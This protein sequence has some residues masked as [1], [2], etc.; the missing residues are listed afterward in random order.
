MKSL[1]APCTVYLPNHWKVIFMELV[2]AL[3]LIIR[4]G[5]SKERDK[6]VMW[7]FF[8]NK[9]LFFFLN[10]EISSNSVASSKCYHMNNWITPK[11]QV[12]SGSASVFLQMWADILSIFNE[13]LYISICISMYLDIYKHWVGLLGC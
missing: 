6:S 1:I 4:N 12:E 5:N 7:N 3:Q 2:L 8:G 13:I 9:A 11:G 10:S